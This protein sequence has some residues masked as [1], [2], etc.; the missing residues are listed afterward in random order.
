[1]WLSNIEPFL[2]LLSHPWKWHLKISWK[3]CSPSW[4]AYKSVWFLKLYPH[5]WHLSYFCGH[6]KSFSLSES[7]SI[8][9]Q[10]RPT[11]YSSSSTSKKSLQLS[12][13]TGAESSLTS[14]KPPG[15][16]LTSSLWSMSEF[17]ISFFWDTNSTLRSLTSYSWNSS[18]WFTSSCKLVASISYLR[19]G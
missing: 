5:S 13:I 18:L 11:Y 19:V 10:S 1:M 3:E 6:W 4:W 7:T 15:I 16:S 2:Y 9:C 12:S 17:R 8:S 14:S